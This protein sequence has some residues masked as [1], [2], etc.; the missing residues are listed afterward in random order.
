M[1][2]TLK[3][4]YLNGKQNMR[5]TIIGLILGLIIAMWAF[6][7]YTQKP[8]VKTLLPPTDSK[9]A[10]VTSAPES[11][12]SE[13]DGAEIEAAIAKKHG[14][15]V[16]DTSMVMGEIT[17]THASG[18]VLFSDGSGWFLAAKDHGVWVDVQDG[19]GTVSCESVAPYNFP[20][21]MVPECVDK[22]GKLIK[23]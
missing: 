14:L 5:N 3:N 12:N 18:T 7:I 9:I 10:A 2:P 6:Y 13:T 21:S 8:L 19:N 16:E 4:L 23:F 15:T 1:K 11:S 22:N 20:V 17:S